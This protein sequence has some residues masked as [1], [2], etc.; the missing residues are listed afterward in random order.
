MNKYPKISII[1]VC[2]NSQKTIKHTV[3]SVRSQDYPNI[4][5]II[6]DGLSTDWT[7]K[8]LEYY[9]D[10]IDHF[11]SENDNGIYDAMNKGIALSKGDIIGILNS[12]D[13]YPNN[14]V[15]SRVSKVFRESGCDCLYGDLLYVNKGYARKI[16]RYWKSGPFSISKLDK[17]WTL[18]HPTF[19][20]KRSVYEKYGYY[21][22]DLS[23]SADYEMILRLLYNYRLNVVYMPEIMVKMRTGG[24]SNATIWNRL[25]GNNQDMKAWELNGLKSPKFLRLR[26]PLSKLSQFIK[27]PKDNE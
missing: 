10:N 14:E 27:R 1:T 15:L 19:F 6:I 22:T 9:K 23:A 16:E 5:Y 20:V 24:E 13:F 3:N 4:E 25:R 11:V 21:N 26:K 7:L 18:P 12:D 8:I 17:G 2:Y